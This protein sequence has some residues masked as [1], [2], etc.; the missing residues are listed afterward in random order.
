MLMVVREQHQKAIQDLRQ[1]LHLQLLVAVVVALVL[2]DQFR[3]YQKM[4]V[5]V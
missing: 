5:M 1:L 2:V 4:V 3:R